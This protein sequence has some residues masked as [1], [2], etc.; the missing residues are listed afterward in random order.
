MLPPWTAE[1]VTFFGINDRSVDSIYSIESTRKYVFEMLIPID[2]QN[3]ISCVCSDLSSQDLSLSLWFSEKPLGDMLFYND[4]P[5]IAP[6]G[7]PKMYMFDN[8]N[9]PIPNNAIT[10]CDINSKKF[11]ENHLRVSPGVYYVNIENKQQ[12]RN[13]FKISF[14][15]EGGMN[16]GLSEN[17][18]DGPV[19]NPN[20]EDCEHSDLG[21]TCSDC[22]YGL[23]KKWNTRIKPCNTCGRI[24]GKGSMMSLR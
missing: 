24:G 17:Q 1:N 22:G 6:Y 15:D 19:H 20:L 14:T 18:S 7:V 11:P 23:S 16:L 4:D 21:E 5:F 2:G 10:I 8:V 9:F 12:R 13:Q 3:Q